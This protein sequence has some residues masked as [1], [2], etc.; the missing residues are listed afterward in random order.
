MLAINRLAKVGADKANYRNSWQRCSLGMVH[1]QPVQIRSMY[2]VCAPWHQ[3]RQS[4]EYFILLEGGCVLDFVDHSVAL[5]P[6]QA[7]KI[8]KGL[9]HRA[10]VTDFARMIVIGGAD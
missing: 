7:F 3:H 8:N 5:S 6:G 2:L 10:R 1:G 9:W 4:Q